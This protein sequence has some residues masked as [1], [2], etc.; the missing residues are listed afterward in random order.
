MAHVR[1]DLSNNRVIQT[2]IVSI[3]LDDQRWA[4]RRTMSRRKWVQNNTTSPQRTFEF[5]DQTGKPPARTLC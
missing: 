3:V 5:F 4:A 2:S 1:R